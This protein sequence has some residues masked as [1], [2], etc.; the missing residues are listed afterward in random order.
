VQGLLDESVERATA[1]ATLLPGGQLNTLGAYRAARGAATMAWSKHRPDKPGAVMNTVITR[2]RTSVLAAICAIFAIGLTAAASARAATLTTQRTTTQ[3]LIVHG[4]H[5]ALGVTRVAAPTGV[6]L[7][8]TGIRAAN[9]NVGG[10]TFAGGSK[11]VY[12]DV[13]PGTDTADEGTCTNIGT[14]IKA[15]YSHLK[16]TLD[17]DGTN[18][19]E[20]ESTIDEI[21]NYENLA[22]DAGCA[23]IY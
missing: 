22:E 4:Q 13:F 1:G 9:S 7:S 12:V 17:H 3:H 23:V 10:L 19:A 11:V 5:L 8:A 21:E 2:S 14:H 15:S 18:S 6:T 20:L 16:F